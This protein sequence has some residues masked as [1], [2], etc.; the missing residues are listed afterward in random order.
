MPMTFMPRSKLFAARW[1]FPFRLISPSSV[2]VSFLDTLDDLRPFRVELRSVR[3]VRFL[4]ALFAE[5]EMSARL[6]SPAT[7]PK[8]PTCH[9]SKAEAAADS[10]ELLTSSRPSH[11]WSSNRRCFPQKWPWQ[12]AQSPTIRWAATEHS[13]KEHLIFLGGMFV[14]GFIEFGREMW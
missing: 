10:G 4:L 14:F 8:T 6:S 3:R 2:I 12:K 1:R 5:D 9:H 7:R 11:L 13:L